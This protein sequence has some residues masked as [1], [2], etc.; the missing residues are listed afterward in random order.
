MVVPIV[1]GVVCVLAVWC[2]LGLALALFIGRA[3][4]IG[5]VKHRDSMF[6]QEAAKH[7]TATQVRL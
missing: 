6:L 7:A 2:A 1:L 3:A 5:E 4:R